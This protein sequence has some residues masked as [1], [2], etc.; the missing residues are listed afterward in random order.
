MEEKKSKKTMII[1]LVILALVVF[2]GVG[3]YFLFFRDGDISVSEENGEVTVGEV[4]TDIDIEKVYTINDLD[5][6]LEGEIW[7]LGEY[8]LRQGADLSDEGTDVFELGENESFADVNVEDVMSDLYITSGDYLLIKGVYEMGEFFPVFRASEVYKISLEE[9]EDFLQ[10]RY[11]LVEIEILEDELVLNHGCEHVSL[12]VSIKNVGE[13]PVDYSKTGS[14]NPEY[15]FMGIVGGEIFSLY[16]DSD[17]DD[18]ESEPVGYKYGFRDFGVIQ[19]GEEKE[20]SF[21][22]D[23]K[24]VDSYRDELK[25]GTAGTPHIFCRG[26]EEGRV[27]TT[28]SIRFGNVREQ[29]RILW[30]GT[31][32]DFVNTFD[33]NEIEVTIL[34]CECDLSVESLPEPL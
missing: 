8:F 32:Y 6:S 1:V 21:G 5:T 24:V 22:L 12:P 17:F 15:V 26:D 28:F 23:G 31:E 18:T 19:P 30:V 4:P 11:P 3:V 16:P 25:V 27:E 20:A 2:L 34:Q 7:L 14:S 13:F 9:Y 29:D 33:S 10:R